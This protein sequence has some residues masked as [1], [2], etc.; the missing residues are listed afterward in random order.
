[1]V[2]PIIAPTIRPPKR[3]ASSVCARACA[4][5][6]PPISFASI[7]PANIAGSAPRIPKSGTITGFK[8]S[9]K[10]GA[11]AIIPTMEIAK[12]PIARIPSSNFSP[13][14]NL[15]PIIRSIISFKLIKHLLIVLRDS[16]EY[17]YWEK[18]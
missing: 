11:R 9:A 8:I 18:V 14:P 15:L 4:S 17:L 16:L 6:A 1:M 5:G 7:V 2:G 10:T 3:P 12:E 13:M